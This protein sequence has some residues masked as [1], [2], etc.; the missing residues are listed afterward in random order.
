MH[1]G[2]ALGGMGLAF[3]SSNLLP[4]VSARE[5]VGVSLVG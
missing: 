2:V 4:R 1:V 3:F 5:C